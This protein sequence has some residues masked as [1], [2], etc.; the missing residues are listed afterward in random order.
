MARRYKSI[1][2]SIHKM[3]QERT[4]AIKGIKTVSDA[5]SVL[6]GRLIGQS[7]EPQISAFMD[8][9]KEARVFDDR[10]NYSRLKKKIQDAAE[11]AGT[12]IPDALVNELDDEV[13]NAVAYI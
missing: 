13:K 9:L 12:T 6:V 10:K 8:E 3:K 11:K 5:F 4:D 1:Y 7:G 2:F